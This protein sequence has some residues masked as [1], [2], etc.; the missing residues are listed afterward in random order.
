MATRLNIIVVEDNDSLRQVTVEILRQHGHRVQGLACAE[1][2]DDAAGGVFADIF[3]LDLNLPSEDG[4]SLAS[5]LRKAQPEVGIIM[6]TARVQ[7]KD[8]ASGYDVGADLYLCK[9][10]AQEEL[11]SAIN[12]LARRLKR[13][14]QP[15]DSLVLDMGKLTLTGK[16]G[17]TTLTSHEA[18]T[19]A[20]FLRAPEQR[21]ESWQ[22]MELHSKSEG[23]S[24]EN[25]EVCITRLRNKLKLITS[26]PHPIKS[27]RKFGYQFCLRV[28]L[29]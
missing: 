8:K 7:I 13:T 25:L 15:D 20:A 4:I 9:P 2:I 10:V 5:R 18:A 19:L 29:Q 1:D 26:E 28:K 6:V 3:I 23:F 27:I 24:K 12:A 17:E 22:L 11:M 21:L 14:A 16:H